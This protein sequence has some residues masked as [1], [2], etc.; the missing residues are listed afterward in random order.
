MPVADG[1]LL[2]MELME[3]S[4]AREFVYRHQWRVG[5]LVV[6]DN[7]CTMHRGRAFDESYPRDLRRVTTSHVWQNASAA[8]Q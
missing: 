6:W 1:R 4:M 3:F 8:A 5:D 2:L 7:C